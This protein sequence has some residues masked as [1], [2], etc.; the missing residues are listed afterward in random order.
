MINGYV[1]LPA[2][3][4][5]NILDK[6]TDGV[7]HIPGIYRKIRDIYEIRKPVVAHFNLGTMG[8]VTVVATIVFNDENN[9]Y[10]IMFDL[11]AGEYL[12]FRITDGDD[13]NIDEAG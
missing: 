6:L 10:I 11:G 5:D 1:N 4:S 13:V 12:T 2:E 8:G 7:L 9:S 3:F